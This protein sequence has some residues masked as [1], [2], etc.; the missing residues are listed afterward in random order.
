VPNRADPPSLR[1]APQWRHEVWEDLRAVARP[2]SRF[3]RRFA[4]FIPDFEGSEAAIDRLLDSLGPPAGRHVFVTPDN[5]LVDLRRRLIGNGASLV[6]ASYNLAR[7]FLHLPA[8]AV[9]RGQALFAAWLDGLEH[10]GRPLDI[11]GLA[12]LGRF[13]WVV[14]GSSAVAVSG[15]RFGRG[16][17][18]F[19]MEWRLFGELG[20]VDEATPVA[21][22]VHDVQLLEQ[23]LMASADDVPVDLILTP[24]RSL[25]VT[26]T[27]PR[28][29]RIDWSRIDDSQLERIPPLR[30]LRHTL[31]L[32]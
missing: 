32:G 2:D 18:Y 19:D 15:V 22:V 11:A 7:G 13:D 23:P 25:R 26:R 6:V 24:T 30:E 9:P 14:T 4:E 3:D 1:A 10:F 5:S 12:A 20:L 27:D 16:H 17:G 31:G 28:P 8:G 29:R 21:T